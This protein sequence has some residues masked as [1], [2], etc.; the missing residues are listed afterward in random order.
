ESMR[1]DLP[2][3]LAWQAVRASEAP[4]LGWYSPRYGVKQPATT[5]AG[6]ALLRGRTMLETIVHFPTAP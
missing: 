6:S 3:A 5:L 1:V 4:M 2:A